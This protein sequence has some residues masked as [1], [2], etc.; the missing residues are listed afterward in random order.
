MD[1]WTVPGIEA[2]RQFVRALAIFVGSAI[3]VA[4]SGIAVT[5]GRRMAVT[6][7]GWTTR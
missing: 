6:S 7:I 5:C 3:G 1:V 4:G 2:W